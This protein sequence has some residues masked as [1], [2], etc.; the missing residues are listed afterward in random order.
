MIDLSDCKFDSA[1]FIELECL[2][3]YTTHVN[4]CGLT[5]S[6][7]VYPNKIVAFSAEHAR[8]IATTIARQEQVKTNTAAVYYNRIVALIAILF[9]SEIVRQLISM[10]LEFIPSTS[11]IY[12]DVQTTNADFEALRH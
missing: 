6:S 3:A 10:H 8:Q 2:L 9:H 7:V 12:N 5:E 1:A 4:L 11:F